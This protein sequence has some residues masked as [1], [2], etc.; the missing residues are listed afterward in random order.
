LLALYS[1]P[2]REAC[3]PQLI[4]DLINLIL[5]GEEQAFK[6]VVVHFYSVSYTNYTQCARL[7]AIRSVL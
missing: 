5:F 1:S 3:P 2:M 6:L 4:L 7:L